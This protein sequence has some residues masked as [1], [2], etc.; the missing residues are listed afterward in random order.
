MN[1][2]RGSTWSPISIEKIWSAAAASSS[3]TCC[4]R[5][6]GRVHRRLAQLVGVHLAEALEALQLDALAGQLRTAPRSSSKESASSRAVAERDLERRRA[7]LLQQ[8]GVHL[9]EL[10]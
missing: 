9:D 7:D 1:S 4:E 6:A 2:R 5:A 10:R 3:V 8:L